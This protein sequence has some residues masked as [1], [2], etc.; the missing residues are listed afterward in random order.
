MTN[1][2]RSQ[3]QRRYYAVICLVVA[4][5]LFIVAMI[6]VA[7]ITRESAAKS[8]ENQRNARINNQIDSIKK[9]EHLL[10]MSSSDITD[11][12]LSERLLKEPACLENIKVV[13]VFGA[14]FPEPISDENVRF[15][16]RLSNLKKVYICDEGNAGVFF[17]QLQGMRS[18]EDIFIDTTPVSR[19]GIQYIATLPNLKQLTFHNGNLNNQGL[20]A[21]RNH[22]TLE[23]LKVNGTKITGDGLAV[24]CEIPKLQCVML[25]NVKMSQT[26]FENLKKLTN[27]K[28][29]CLG[30][31][32]LDEPEMVELQKALPNC[33]ITN[34][35]LE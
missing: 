7:S 30:D 12:K 28:E 26:G 27:L 9:G 22:P 1:T 3:S 16:S 8:I 31:W 14:L 24:L 34:E 17:K 4:I 33:K 19:V 20:A 11:S 2:V 23:T 6:Y 15:L 29:L 10:L 13:N 21:I 35:F 18:V 5:A 25:K 32:R